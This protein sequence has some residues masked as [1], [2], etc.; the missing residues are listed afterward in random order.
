MQSVN[1]TPKKL[2]LVAAAG[3]LAVMGI[4]TFTAGNSAGTGGANSVMADTPS[5]QAPVS[6]PSVPSAVPAVK[7][8]KFAGGD[9][10][11]M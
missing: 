2:S 3:A 6:T 9:W 8:T 7:A 10:T 11:G 5:V 1:V 4:M